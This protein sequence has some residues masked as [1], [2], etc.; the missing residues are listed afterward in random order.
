MKQSFVIKQM[1]FERNCG[2]LHLPQSAVFNAVSD[3]GIPRGDAKFAR[4]FGTGVPKLRGCQNH[5]DSA[6][7]DAWQ[8]NRVDLCQINISFS[9]EP[10]K[11]K[12]KT[13]TTYRFNL[14]F[15]RLSI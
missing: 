8:D 5:C 10:R 9:T 2:C 1:V 7:W 11:T 4:D 6:S 14:G 3:F 12:K 15:A 13:G